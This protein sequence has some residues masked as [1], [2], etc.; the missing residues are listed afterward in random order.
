MTESAAEYDARAQANRPTDIETLRRE[1]QPE[2]I[3]A[4]IHQQCISIEIAWLSLGRL[5]RRRSDGPTPIGGVQ[6]RAA[7]Q[8]DHNSYNLKCARRIR[9]APLVGI[10]AL[11]I[12]RREGK[13]T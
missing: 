2:A 8:R 3:W 1:P 10:N 9:Q 4:S 13:I 6:S 5:R 7:M 12:P 11:P